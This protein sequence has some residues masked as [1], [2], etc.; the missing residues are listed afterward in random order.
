MVF[1][2]A[3]S[4]FLSIALLAAGIFLILSNKPAWDLSKRLSATERVASIDTKHSKIIKEDRFSDIQFLHGILKRIRFV[5]ALE[6]LLE[7]AGMKIR[8]GTLIL[9]MMTVGVFSGIPVMWAGRGLL[10]TLVI[11]FLTG[12]T[13]YLYVRYRCKKRKGLF[14]EQFPDALEMMVRSL[15]VGHSLSTAMQTVGDEMPDPVGTEF[16]VAFKEQSLGRS[17]DNSMENMAR[18][19]ESLDVDFFITSV[20]IQRE[21]GGNLAENLDKLGHTIRE[22]FKIKGYLQAITAEGRLS[23]YVLG[24]LPFVMGLVFYLLNPEYIGLLFK[25]E[26]GQWLL[27]AGLLM[28]VIGFLLIKKIVNIKV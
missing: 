6:Y 8:V 28:Q 3:A 21:T 27:G 2:I 19:L 11:S 17:I 5:F 14:E 24:A 20:N 12:S 9:S 15:R 22:R 18:R 10:C 4:V 23:G 16:K 26:F 25:E 13:P 1:L 7:Q